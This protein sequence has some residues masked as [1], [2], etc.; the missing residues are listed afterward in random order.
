M[1][2]AVTRGGQL[3]VGDVADPVPAS[4]HVVARSLAAG[5]CGSDL[6]ALADFAHF[7][8]LMDSVGVPSLDPAADCV[9]GHEFCAEIVEHGP[10]TAGTLPV[11]HPGLLGAH[12][13]GPDRRRADRLLQHVP[14]RAGRA[15]GAPGAAAPAGARLA[16]DRPGRADRAA[17]RGRARRR[18]GRPRRGATVPGRGL[19]PGG[20]GRHR[21]PQGPR[22]RP[23]AGGRLLADPPPPG[24]GLRGRR[25]HRPGGGI[26]A[27]S[28]GDLRRAPHR[29]GAHGVFGARRRHQGPGHLRG[30]RRAR[31]AA[32]AHRRGAAAQPHRGGGR[33]H[34]H[35]HHRAVHGRDQGDRA[36]LLLRLHPGRVRGHPR[37]GWAP[38]CPGPTCW[39]PPPSTWPARRAPSRRCAPRASTARSWSSHRD[40]D[41]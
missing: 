18:P 12:R 21:R 22:P 3:V 1:Q 26:A 33:V 34:A 35:R 15:H 31:H 14:G 36:A 23:G 41:R 13:R 8:G 10:D 30:G 38:A 37:A 11:G 16:R 4:G 6:H 17:G 28:L 27:R 2:A 40:G 24:R 25:G 32:V 39:S 20:P 5:I 29:H 19:R 9:F 7:T